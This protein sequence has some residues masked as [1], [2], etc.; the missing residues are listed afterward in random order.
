MQRNNRPEPP[1]VPYTVSGT[2]D[3]HPPRRIARLVE[4]VGVRKARL[5]TLP[6][7]VLGFLAGVYIAFGGM[8]YTL[9]VADPA[10]AGGAGRLV[11]GLAFSIGLILVVIAGAELFTGNMLIVM[12][13]ADGL[14]SGKE[15]R[16]NWAIVWAANFAGGFAAAWAVR[17]AGVYGIGEGRVA[18]TAAAIAEAKVA[19]EF[20]PALMRGVLANI[21]V[22]LAVWL[23]FASHTVTDRILSIML[24]VAVFVALGFEHSVA[25]MYLIPVGMMH[26]AEGVGLGDIAANLVPVTLGNMIGGGAGVAG[27]YWAVYLR[28]HGSG[29]D[30]G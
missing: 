27:V 25:N 21:L 29:E 13:W 20:W 7:V 24:P 6:L 26:G 17:E 2:I 30:E 8:A 19:L 5:A 22:C 16:R 12:A 1:P 3:A 23:C 10:M 9:I 11:G 15:L 14:I 18:V 4:D 28:R